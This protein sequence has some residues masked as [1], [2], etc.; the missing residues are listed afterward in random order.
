MVWVSV[1]CSVGRRSSCCVQPAAWQDE[2]PPGPTR[3]GPQVFP[4]PLPPATPHPPAFPSTLLCDVGLLPPLSS[5]PLFKKQT[6][7]K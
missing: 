4:A 3:L 5:S 1:M 6:A 2:G 7:I